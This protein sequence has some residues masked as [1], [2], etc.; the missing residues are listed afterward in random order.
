MAVHRYVGL[1]TCVFLVIAALT[2]CVLCFKQPLDAWLN[3]ELF[4]P[5]AAGQADPIAAAQR[6]EAQHPDLVVSYLNIRPRP[7]ENWVVAV[8]ARHGGPPAPFDQAFLDAGDGRLVG[9]RKVALG[10]DR[11]HLMTG[12]FQLHDSLLG[13]TPGRLLLGGVAVAW[14][15]SNLVGLYLTW[16]A[17]GPY[18]KR[19]AQAFA[20][21][22]GALARV[23]LD[24]H[25]ASGL[26]LLAPLTV[27]AFT[28]VAMNFFSEALVPAVQAVAP[29]RPSPFDRPPPADPGPRR[30][31]Y[32]EALALSTA[33]AA[34]DLPG[35]R[36]AVLQYE[37]DRN[38][39][40]VRLTHSGREGYRGLGPVTYWFDGASKRF[41]YLDN[42]YRDSAG[43]K[44][45]RAL[46][47][48]HTGQMIGWPG[49]A[50]DLILGLVT[51]G[52]GV[53]GVYLWLKRRPGRVA[54]R[55]ART[56]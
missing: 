44:L 18:L 37:A 21:R 38:L 32:G 46:Y 40:G 15:A 52:G 17:R 22:R 12:V 2:G 25:R 26:W 29:P 1:V 39:V 7:G 20:V 49:I 19:W 53:T 4:R 16:P 10:W 34:T 56:G 13:G 55:R 54:A 35:W 47:P 5:R 51:A 41:V 14:L 43:Q 11:P 30:L 48:L 50:L 8:E 27:L 45:I 33:R 42:P 31:G 3:P 24:L 9:T 23:L 28:S 36:P 6:L